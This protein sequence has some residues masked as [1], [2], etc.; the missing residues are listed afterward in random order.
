MASMS[1]KSAWS[2]FPFKNVPAPLANVDPKYVNVT[3]S[4]DPRGFGSNETN[5]Q[6]GLSGVSNNA[7]AA[8]ASALKGGARTRTHSLRR[9]I[10]NIANKYKKMKGGKSR[11]MTLG[12]IK[13]K[14]SS[15]LRMGKSKRRHAKKSKK[16]VSR[17]H[18]G[19]KRQ[20]GGYSQWM[21]NVA[22]TPS[23]ST[24]GHL[25]ANESALANPVPYH[26]TNNCVDNYNH[27]TNKGFQ[28]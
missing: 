26:P 25:S 15:I 3:N 21:S 8:A 4:N 9:K 17:R 11:K 20:R 6:W 13:R 16:N 7:Q 27:Y 1:M 14:L 18:R 5:R 12:S 2:P 10:K 19:T 23:Y 22:Y 28:M 24:G